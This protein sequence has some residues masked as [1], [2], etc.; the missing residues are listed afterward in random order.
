MRDERCCGH[1]IESLNM[2]QLVVSM[3]KIIGSCTKAGRC[4]DQCLVPHVLQ[5]HLSYPGG[6]AGGRRRPLGRSRTLQHGPGGANLALGF[7]LKGL[8]LGQYGL[9]ELL[10]STGSP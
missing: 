2:V 3:Q 8:E 1:R 10:P 4:C 9:W 5:R 6:A 7:R